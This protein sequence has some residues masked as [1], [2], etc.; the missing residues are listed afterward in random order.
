MSRFN[1]FDDDEDEDTGIKEILTEKNEN[2]KSIAFSPLTNIINNIDDEIDDKYYKPMKNKKKK[3]QE[4]YYSRK[5]EQEQYYNKKSEFTNNRTYTNER[6]ID[7]ENT[8][9][10]DNFDNHVNNNCVVIQNEIFD[11]S[12]LSNT[13]EK[14]KIYFFHIKNNNWNDI[15]NFQNV[16]D[17]DVWK[18]IPEIFNSFYSLKTKINNYNLFFMKNKISPLWESKENRGAGRINIQIYDLDETINFLKI[19]LINNSNKTLLI[20]KNYS[21]TDINGFALLPKIDAK[22]NKSYQII[23][24]WFSNNI[25]RNISK[26][27]EMILNTHI[28]QLLLTNKYS[29]RVKIHKQQY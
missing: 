7:F 4:Q 23:Q 27:H 21:K 20:S 22:E 3:K 12:M 8:K 24:I 16:Y 10:E 14:V 25:I 11:V 15:N 2:S 17:I 19:L 13:I 9:K 26:N 18:D 29:V 5:Q 6:N 28:T 1:V